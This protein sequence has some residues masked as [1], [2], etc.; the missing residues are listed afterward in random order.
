M[1]EKLLYVPISLQHLEFSVSDL[2]EKIIRMIQKSQF[3]LYKALREPRLDNM[4]SLVLTFSVTMRKNFIMH[5]RNMC[6]LLEMCILTQQTRKT[7]TTGRICFK[8]FSR[9][10][11]QC[12]Q[13]VGLGGS[14]LQQTFH[15]LI[16]DTK[17]SYD[18]RNK[19]LSIPSVLTSMA[20]NHQM[21][22][23]V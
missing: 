8:R 4:I 22:T 6:S 23:I 21:Q 12:S 14:C 1:R 5:Y 9:I 10:S 7:P 19:C 18:N 3:K 11:M 16:V 13:A 20:Q 17:V 2:W 15:F